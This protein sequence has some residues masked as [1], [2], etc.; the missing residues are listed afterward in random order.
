MAHYVRDDTVS[1][2]FFRGEPVPS[3]N[4]ISAERHEAFLSFID[5]YINN[6]LGVSSNVEDPTHKLEQVGINIYRQLLL[7]LP[8]AL[9]E[10]DQSILLGV[11]SSFPIAVVGPND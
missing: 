10:E 4:T 1:H 5:T 7:G 2:I 6:I 9:T 8:V 3:D 11:R